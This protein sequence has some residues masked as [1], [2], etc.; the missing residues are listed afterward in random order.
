[1]RSGRAV[2]QDGRD[3]KRVMHIDHDAHARIHASQLLDPHNRCRE[4]HA[5][6]AVFL[7]DFNA[8]EP[9]LEAALDDLG[10]H[11]LGLVHGAHARRN[12]LGG[13]LLDAIC[14]HALRLGHVRDGCW[15]DVGEVGGLADGGLQA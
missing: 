9:L 13:E 7:W 6:A 14:H 5:A 2:L 11:R 3:D 12:H 15:W 4:V 1:M 10:I 8:H